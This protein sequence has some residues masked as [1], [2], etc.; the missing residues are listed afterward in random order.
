MSARDNPPGSGN[1]FENYVRSLGGVFTKYVDKIGKPNFKVTTTGEFQEVALYTWGLMSIWGFNYD[2]G[3]A[4]FWWCDGENYPFYPDKESQIKSKL[5][6][7]K[8]NI[9]ELCSGR[10][11]PDL[12]I[13]P[14]DKSKGYNSVM[15]EF[16]YLKNKDKHKLKQM[17]ENATKLI[18]E[19]SSY[20]EIKNIEGLH[21]FIIVALNDKL[22]V[23]EIT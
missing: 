8:Y 14:Q 2:A 23:K 12:L 20:N 21:K 18:E 6:E 16:K 10:K 1:G 15:I 7:P 9:N 4:H 22:Y 5:P 19:Y 17:Q 11:Y 13:T 3:S